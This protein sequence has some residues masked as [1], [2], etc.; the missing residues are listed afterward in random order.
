[1]EF[2]NGQT[3]EQA[4]TAVKRLASRMSKMR[5]LDTIDRFHDVMMSN[6]RYEPTEDSRWTI[7][8]HDLYVDAL[9]A[10]FPGKL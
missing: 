7:T 10:R 2:A 8:V 1:M 5:L 6:A 3:Q 9:N 4:I